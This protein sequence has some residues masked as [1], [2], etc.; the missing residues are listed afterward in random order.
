MLERNK[1]KNRYLQ[2][3]VGSVKPSKERKGLTGSNEASSTVLSPPSRIKFAEPSL[4][5][6]LGC[7]VDLDEELWQPLSAT[8]ILA[9]FYYYYESSRRQAES[10]K[11]YS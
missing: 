6:P 4:L 10:P 5:L 2:Q 9:V 8:V 1:K 3:S 11:P 7:A